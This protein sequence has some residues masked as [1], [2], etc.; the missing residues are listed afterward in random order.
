[1]KKV[2]IVYEDN[3]RCKTPGESCGA[4]VTD[5]PKEMG[6]KGEALSPTDMVVF[7]LGSCMLTMMAFTAQKNGLDIKGTKFEGYEVMVSQPVR[8]IGEI[9]LTFAM[10]PGIPVSKR[11]MLEDAADL[12]PVRKSLHP[13]IRCQINFKYPD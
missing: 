8:R 7:A 11:K 12:C 3:L 2:F 9:T 13:D 1:M 5:A 6:G 4:I 10:N